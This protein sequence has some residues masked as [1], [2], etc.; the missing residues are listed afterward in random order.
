MKQKTKR[1]EMG[2]WRLSITAMLK[3]MALRFV[4]P[5]RTIGRVVRS[6]KKEQLL[7][8]HKVPA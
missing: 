1:G 7:C 2:L 4:N 3:S 6:A 8:F 5:A